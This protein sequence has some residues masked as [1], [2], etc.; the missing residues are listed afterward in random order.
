MVLNVDEPI[1]CVYQNILSGTWERSETEYARNI[2][3]Q[4]GFTILYGLPY[5]ASH[6]ISVS[7]NN[8]V[9]AK[10]APGDPNLP[11]SGGVLD[12]PWFTWTLTNKSGWHIRKS[13]L[14]LI[15][16]IYT[17]DCS[18]KTFTLYIGSIEWYIDDVLVF[19]GPGPY[20]DAGAMLIKDFYTEHF[21]RPVPPGVSFAPL[22]VYPSVSEIAY[23]EVTGKSVGGW[24]V[25][26]GR[27]VVPFE[28]CFDL[29]KLNP[30]YVYYCP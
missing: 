17:W 14:K 13:Y 23:F 25:L 9:P 15:D 4:A 28:L 2:G 26:V 30:A 7:I 12:T 5:S 18:S 27:S 19:T 1:T 29:Q 24:G 3:Q 22:C 8:S 10:A 6:G 16:V 11:I 21:Y 20:V